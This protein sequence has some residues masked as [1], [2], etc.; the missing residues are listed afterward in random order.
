MSPGWGCLI[1][2][3]LRALGRAFRWIVPVQPLL[4]LVP[5]GDVE[6]MTKSKQNNVPQ[7]I[8]IGA[9]V[10][11]PSDSN[12]QQPE[13]ELH[14]VRT[15]GCVTSTQMFQQGSVAKIFI[16]ALEN[17]LRASWILDDCY[18]LLAVEDPIGKMY[19][20]IMNSTK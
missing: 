13:A 2:Q 16:F 1:N 5:V 11:I 4:L 6:I 15:G 7:G 19:S 20:R 9:D 3:L 8:S 14:P 10:T 18:L 17:Y 12:R